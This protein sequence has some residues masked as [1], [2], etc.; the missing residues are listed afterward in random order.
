[1]RKIIDLIKKSSSIAILTHISEDADALCSAAALF[2][3]LKDMNKN[4]VIYVNDTPEDKLSFLDFEYTVY[5]EDMDIPEYDLCICL[6]CGDLNRL[7]S[8]I[9]IFNKAKH[10]VNIDHHY[11]NPGYADENHI[12]GN[13]SSTG[14][15]L[16]TFLKK[17][18]RGLSDRVA[19]MLYT[20]IV[21]DSGG[22]RYSNT[23]PKTLM[24]A[25]ELLKFDFEHAE[26]CRMIFETE[27]REI[28][29]F[30]GYV[31]ENIHEYF[32][33]K[34]CIAAADKSDYEKFEITE[35]DLGDLVNIP[36]TLKGCEIAVSV[37]E[38]LTK[39]KISFRSNG[40]FDVSGLAARFGG[41]GHKMAAGASMEDSVENV[42]KKIVEVCSEMF[43]AVGGST[44]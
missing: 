27:K 26:I 32:D 10:T 6:D 28:V 7:G 14:E 39:T 13:S 41:G 29:K 1:M 35:K 11:T 21:S 37:R 40:R 42:E 43:F 25:S 33:G 44:K 5:S 34:L 36:R 31:M 3:I 2:E 9:E 19:M 12:E 8:R 23:S 22:F 18:K 15:I 38:G 16:Y 4:A 17:L 30:K 20:A 24:I